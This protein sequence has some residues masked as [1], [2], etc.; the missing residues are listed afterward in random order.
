M[1]LLMAAGPCACGWRPRR[2]L[3]EHRPDMDYL[4][5][6]RNYST[7]NIP[8][9]RV[10]NV[11]MS[12]LCCSLQYKYGIPLKTTGQGQTPGFHAADMPDFVVLV[13]TGLNRVGGNRANYGV[14]TRLLWSVRLVFLASVSCRSRAA[15][16]QD[17]VS[18]GTLARG[19]HRNRFGFAFRQ[20]GM[21]QRRLARGKDLTLSRVSSVMSH[22]S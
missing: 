8:K 7:Y 5:N 15:V 6:F 22:S 17:T 13:M 3:C 11:S 10:R 16:A 2:V 21:K 1:A 9:Y 18:E 4:Q 19:W 14:E 12:T 20:F